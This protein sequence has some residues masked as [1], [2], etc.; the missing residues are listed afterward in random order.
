MLADAVSSAVYLWL[1][2]LVIFI[3]FLLLG[4][5]VHIFEVW[6]RKRSGTVRWGDWK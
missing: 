5:L 3:V 6:Y 4:G 2:L 1:F